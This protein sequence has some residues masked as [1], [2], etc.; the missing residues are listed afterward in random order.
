MEDPCLIKR[1][2]PSPH[3]F[4]RQ[5]NKIVNRH[6]VRYTAARIKYS[7]TR[8][9][10]R[11]FLSN[12]AYT[13][14]NKND[15]YNEC[16]ILDVYVLIVKNLNPFSLNR[17]IADKM[18]HEMVYMLWQECMPTEFYRYI[19]DGDNFVYLNGKNVTQPSVLDI[20]GNFIDQGKRNLRLLQENLFKD[21]FQYVY[22]NVYPEVY[23]TNEKRG[24]D[25]KSNFH[26]LFKTYRDKMSMRQQVTAKNPVNYETERKET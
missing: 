13:G 20:V 22:S 12:I 16:F 11:N 2:T 3:H 17:K 7:K 18:K 24:F 5:N 8:I 6:K 25:L 10:S 1:E 26:I 19:C 15:F 9:K 23:A 21:I 14:I 4:S